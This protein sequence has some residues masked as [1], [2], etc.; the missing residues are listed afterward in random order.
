MAR[1]YAEVPMVPKVPVVPGF[2]F[3]IPVV[4]RFGFTDT[5]EEHPERRNHGT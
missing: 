4:S 3:R 1:F 5:R 2:W